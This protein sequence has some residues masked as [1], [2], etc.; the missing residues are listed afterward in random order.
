MVVDEVERWGEGL[1]FVICAL[2]TALAGDQVFTLI[3]VPGFGSAWVASSALQLGEV[4][5]DVVLVEATTVYATRAWC[6][7]EVST[8]SALDGCYGGWI[9][10]DWGV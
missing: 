3:A 2:A 10:V 7:W 1:L 9:E 8:M 6:E 4:D 5:G